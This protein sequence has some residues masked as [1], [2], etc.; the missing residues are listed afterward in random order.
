MSAAL[1]GA[2]A[3]IF[4]GAALAY[5]HGHFVFAGLVGL[6]YA[7]VIGTVVVRS[8]GT[9]VAVVVLALLAV[10]PGLFVLVHAY[11]AKRGHILLPTVYSIP[12][13][14]VAGALLWLVA[15]VGLAF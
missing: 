14:F 12:I 3:V 5:Y 13:A 15:G 10:A 6:V 4:A 8:M 7:G 1:F 11:D 9:A 2:A